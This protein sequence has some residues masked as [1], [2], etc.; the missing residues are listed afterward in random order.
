MNN[1]IQ[2][3]WY[4][5]CKDRSFRALILIITAS[6]LFWSIFQYIDR[7]MDG[8]SPITGIEMW[9]S[10]LLGNYIMIIGM[11]VL[12]GFFISSE[13]TTGVMKSIASSGNSRGR[14][15]AAKQLVFALGSV[16]LGLLFPLINCV[17][18]TLLSSFGELPGEATSLYFIRSFGMLILYAAAFA[19]ITTLIATLMAESGKTIAFTMVFFLFIDMFFAVA[20]QYIPFVETIYSYTVFKLLYDIGTVSLD[21]SLLFRM[22]VIPIITFVCFGMLNTWVYRRKEIK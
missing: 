4:K 21:G 10:A 14:I 20:G 2:S 19:S 5:L 11:C 15:I 22:I 1:L 17:V 7:R 6:G 13:Y 18:A 16:I 3:E 12:A 8:E 9:T